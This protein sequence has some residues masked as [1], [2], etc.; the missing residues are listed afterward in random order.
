MS[1]GIARG[2]RMHQVCSRFDDETLEE[3]D[4][5]QR[6]RER[7]TRVPLS[8]SLIVLEIVESWARERAKARAGARVDRD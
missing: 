1:H 8:R 4:R 6:E 2:K 7:S 5:Y 3:V